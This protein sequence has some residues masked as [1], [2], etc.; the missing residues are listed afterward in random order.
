[1]GFKK[2][3]Q[4]PNDVVDGITRS[5]TIMIEL[6]IAKVPMLFM[7]SKKVPLV[8]MPA[9]NISV[10]MVN[11]S[12]DSAFIFTEKTLLNISSDN[13]RMIHDATQAFIEKNT[14]KC[15]NNNPIQMY[16]VEYKRTG[17]VSDSML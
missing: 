16:A 5:R 2:S 15:F 3:N 11:V 9:P 1:M 17:V 12:T 13:S 14:S 10:N 8:V 4:P 6:T 7:F